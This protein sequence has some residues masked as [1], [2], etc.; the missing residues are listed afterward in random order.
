MVD[1]VSTATPQERAERAAEELAAAGHPV[2]SRAVRERSG[3]RM[4]IAAQTARQ[5]NERAAE[6]EHVPEAPTTVRARI[7]GIWREAYVAAREE[8]LVQRDALADK[9]RAVEEERDALTTDLTQAES[10]IEFLQDECDATRAQAEQ[11]ATVVAAEHAEM[12]AAERSRAD[13]A[14]GALE[15]VTAERDR[16]LAQIKSPRSGKRD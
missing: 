7:D 5:W 9:L 16:L 10:R 8:F 3:V 15:A 13:R 1:L 12:L 11:A 2:S 6:Q 4:A 14:E